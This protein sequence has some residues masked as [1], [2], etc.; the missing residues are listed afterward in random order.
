MRQAQES[1][2]DRSIPVAREQEIAGGGAGAE[3]FLWRFIPRLDH[4]SSKAVMVLNAEAVIRFQSLPV[5]QFLGYAADEIVGHPLLSFLD[6]NSKKAA[7]KAI[8]RM[9]EFGERFSEWCFCFQPAS[10]KKL[11]LKGRAVNFLKDPRLAGI[12]VYWD[13]LPRKEEKN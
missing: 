4:T 13:E 7:R 6:S 1:E 8:E 11:W 3:S 12:M 2:S 9:A 10:G 5:E